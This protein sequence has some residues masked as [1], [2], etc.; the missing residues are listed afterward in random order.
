MYFLRKIQQRYKINESNKNDFSKL[1][2]W[3]MNKPNN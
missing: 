3:R 2:T 1:T